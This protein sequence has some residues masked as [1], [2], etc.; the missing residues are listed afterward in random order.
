MIRTAAFTKTYDAFQLKIPELSLREGAVIAVAGPNG[1]G[2]STLGKCLSGILQTDQKTSPLNVSCGYSP[3][4]SYAFNKSLRGNVLINASEPTVADAL[5]EKLGLTEL[6]DV[7]AKKLSG[8]QVARMALARILA[9]SYELLILDEPT[10]SMDIES[11]LRSEHCIR[12][13]AAK[14]GSVLLI[15]H[16]L[17]QAKR[18]ADEIILMDCG[19]I[20]EQNDTKQLLSAPQ[21]P[22]TKRFLEFFRHD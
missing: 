21:D 22:R 6:S 4:F 20:I 12:E 8:G 18:I 10:A 19:Q 5:I 9:G 3:Q 14:K 7:N 13:Y 1:C 17:A 11:T 2:K 15:T 16:S